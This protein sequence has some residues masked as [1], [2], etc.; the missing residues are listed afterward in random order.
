MADMPAHSDSTAP[1]GAGSIA[2]AATAAGVDPS[3]VDRYLRDGDIAELRG[4]TPDALAALVRTHREVAA[5]RRPDATTVEV[6]DGVLHIVTGD[7]PFLVDSVLAVLA[8]LVVAGGLAKAGYGV[9]GPDGKPV[10]LGRA[11][12]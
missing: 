6:V 4:R 8:S 7:R 10:G 5:E 9:K 2:E 3:F 12:R 11:K 1:D